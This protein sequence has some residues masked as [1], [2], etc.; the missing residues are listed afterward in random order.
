MLA[1]DRNS[2]DYC[3]NLANLA[4]LAKTVRQIKPF[5]IVN[6][7]AYTDVDKA[8]SETKLAKTINTDAVAVLAQEAKTL[9][10]WLVHYSTD[11]VFAGNGT[12][13]YKEDATT[14][15]LS[16]YGASKLAR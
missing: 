4:G 9:K 7:A 10:A 13:L 1:L 8:E 5:I 11:Y 12:S 15:P 6:A 2:Q 14:N 16:V 3:G